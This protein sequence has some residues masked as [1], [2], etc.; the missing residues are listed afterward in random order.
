MHETGERLCREHSIR[1]V[2]VELEHIKADMDDLA[3][4]KVA[5]R[6]AE[7]ARGRVRTAFVKGH[8]PEMDT[9]VG[10]VV[11]EHGVAWSLFE[12]RAEAELWLSRKMTPT[13]PLDRA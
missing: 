4:Y 11:R 7:F 2:L 6:W 9:F 1:S 5:R 8:F 3:L 12:T 13:G 10:E